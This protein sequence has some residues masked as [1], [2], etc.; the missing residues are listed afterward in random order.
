[1]FK[2]RENERF[3][4][5]GF[6]FGGRFLL[7]RFRFVVVGSGTF[8]CRSSA[9]LLGLGHVR[10]EVDFHVGRR[11]RVRTEF[12]L[13]LFGLLRFSNFFRGTGD[14]VPPVNHVVELVEIVRSSGTVDVVSLVVLNRRNSDSFWRL[15]LV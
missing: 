5:F 4:L 11:L 1:M 13:F 3:V 6:L 12:E 7:D 15:F 8:L 2:I 10:V 14:G 9:L